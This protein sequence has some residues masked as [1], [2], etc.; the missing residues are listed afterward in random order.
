MDAWHEA[1][2]LY[3]VDR[4]VDEAL[5][6][7][8]QVDATHPKYATA[9]RY[10]GHNIYG[11]ELGRW[12]EAVPFVEAALRAAPDDPKVLEDA[13]RVFVNVGRVDEG[14]ALLIRADTPVAQ[15]ALSRMSDDA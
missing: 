11:R 14:R 9:M 2:Q 13:G 15:R 10:I 7:Y 6:K 8:K 4:Q 1:N 3:F 12:T 5:K